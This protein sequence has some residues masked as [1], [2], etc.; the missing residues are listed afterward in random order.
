M[1]FAQ[2]AKRY[3]EIA[4]TAHEALFCVLRTQQNKALYI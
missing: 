1:S 3:I 2:S 4:R